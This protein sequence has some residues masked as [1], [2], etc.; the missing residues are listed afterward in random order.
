MLTKILNTVCIAAFACLVLGFVLIEWKFSLLPLPNQQTKQNPY[1]VLGGKIASVAAPKSSDDRIADYTW[2]LAVLTGALVVTALGQGFFIARSDKTARMAAN[3][4]KVSAET[5]KA[6]FEISKLELRA[7]L[8][9]KTAIMRNLDAIPEATVELINSGRTK[10][11]DVTFWL[12]MGFRP[13]PPPEGAFEKPREIVAS[14]IDLGPQR[15]VINT[16][17]FKRQP[18]REEIDALK[19]IQVSLFV[20]GEAVYTDIFGDRH[21]LP[22]R[23]ATGGPYGLLTPDGKLAICEEGNTAT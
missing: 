12:T 9:L 17:V 21:T 14:K 13:I 16:V 10:A 8:A 5:A 22:V 19:T 20:F 4:A 18:S 7:D 15:T 3:A 6:S 23:L 11:K 2:W 1:H